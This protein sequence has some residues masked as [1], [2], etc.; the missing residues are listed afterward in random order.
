MVHRRTMFSGNGAYL[1]TLDNYFFLS[2][3]I[4]SKANK[5]NKVENTSALCQLEEV[6]TK[7]TQLCPQKFKHIEKEPRSFILG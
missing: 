3:S 7:G 2:L 1:Y 5:V 6:Y 4:M